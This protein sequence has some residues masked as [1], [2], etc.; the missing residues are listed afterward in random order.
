MFLRKI[1]VMFVPIVLLAL[2]CA[3]LPALD[4]L[5]FFSSVA[6]GVV[7]GAVLALLLPLSGASRRREPFGV[8]LWVPLTLIAMVVLYQYLAT[9]GTSIPV[10]ALLETTNPQIVHMECTFLGFM[11][12]TCIR[13]AG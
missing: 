7:L 9:C 12:V 3:I 8:L 5:G 4:G 6:K 11:A 10:L 2:V 13:T 1:T